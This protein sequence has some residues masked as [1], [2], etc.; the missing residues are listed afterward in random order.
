MSETVRTLGAWPME[1]G[2]W[3]D[4]PLDERVVE[5]PLDCPR[6]QY[7]RIVNTLMRFG[8]RTIDDVAAFDPFRRY[9]GAVGAGT[10][11]SY[12]Y[13]AG[14][15]RRYR[16]L[17]R[18]ALKARGRDDSRWREPRPKPRKQPAVCPHCGGEL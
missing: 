1:L 10:Y 11:F 18:D 17:V 14:L 9:E 12:T 2:E 7:V 3:G 5:L 15:G 4:T 6:P 16:G 8:C 13:T